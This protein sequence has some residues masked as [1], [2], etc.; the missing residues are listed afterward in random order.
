MY[1][2]DLRLEYVPKYCCWITGIS[3]FAHIAYLL[4]LQNTAVCRAS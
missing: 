2:L 3:Q 1:S 4:I